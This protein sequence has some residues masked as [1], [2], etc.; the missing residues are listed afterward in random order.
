[1][2]NVMIWGESPEGLHSDYLLSLTPA[3]NILKSSHTCTKPYD[4]DSLITLIRREDIDA[5]WIAPHTT[6][7]LLA[8]EYPQRFKTAPHGQKIR[9]P[10]Q[11]EMDDPPT[12]LHIWQEDG[13]S[14]ERRTIRLFFPEHDARWGLMHASPE[15]LLYAVTGAERAMNGILDYSPGYSGTLLLKACTE[16]HWWTR[17][18]LSELNDASDLAAAF[19]CK[20][21]EPVPDGINA[22]WF[23]TYDK[24]AQ[25]LGAAA[26][27]QVG[28]G[29]PRHHPFAKLGDVKEHQPGIW[30]IYLDSVPPVLARSYVLGRQWM[31][32]PDIWMLRAM[33]AEF[34]L[35]DAYIWDE[36]HPALRTWAEKLWDARQ[37]VIENPAAM[38]IIKAC[39][40]QTI[41][42]FGHAP[43]NGIFGP[44]SRRD[45]QQMI[46]S[47]ASSL[48]RYKI[49]ELTR[50]GY[51]VLWANVDEIG[52]Y[53]PE[54]D[55]R[56]ACPEL[57]RH[58]GQLGG[59]RPRYSL[60]FDGGLLD[61]FHC[62]ITHGQ[63]HKELL[64]LAALER[65]RTVSAQKD[66]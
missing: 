42:W 64:R 61:L 7:S 17:C 34:E 63:A 29:D 3:G 48:M 66:G 36:S 15:Q 8:L 62:D 54:A 24:A 21:K 43:D 50:K 16:W 14:R 12:C 45:A 33:R 30:E 10:Q 60:R 57:V 25:F 2:Y 47:R 40:T 28:C 9:I 27:I 44:F 46:I 31:W 39:Y 26:H 59:F 35:G 20:F 38:G 5:L 49:W 65:A 32:T 51:A 23:H 53:S 55:P 22:G 18:D 6:L 4:L 1:V 56:V 41:G 19:S 37:A 52:I 13:N 58:E 11:I